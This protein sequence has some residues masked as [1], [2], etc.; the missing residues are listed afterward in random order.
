MLQLQA[1]A[2]QA[3]ERVVLNLQVPQGSANWHEQAAFPHRLRISIGLVSKE[4]GC[5]AGLVWQIV[6]PPSGFHCQCS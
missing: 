6:G 5:C 3:T 2:S 1:S 4:N